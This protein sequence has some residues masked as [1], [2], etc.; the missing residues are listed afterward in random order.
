[1]QKQ[2]LKTYKIINPNEIVTKKSINTINK[3]Q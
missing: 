3:D 2:K 1:M